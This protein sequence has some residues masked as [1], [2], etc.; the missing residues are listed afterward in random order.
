MHDFTHMWNTHLG[1]NLNLHCR[2]QLQP[3]STQHNWVQYN[4]NCPKGGRVCP[5]VACSRNYRTNPLF[6]VCVLLKVRKIM[7]FF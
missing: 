3:K 2:N 4:K 1:Y 5:V 6:I 7:E